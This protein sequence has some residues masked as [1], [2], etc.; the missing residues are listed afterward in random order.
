MREHDPVFQQ[1]GLDGETPIWFLTRYDDVVAMLLDDERFVL[2][3]ALALTPEEL[4]AHPTPIPP[5]LDELINTHVLTTDGEDHRRL[6]RLV[7]KA[8]TPSMVE[9][10]RPRIQEIADELLDRVEA[11]AASRP[12]RQ[13]RVPA[14][15]HR[16]RRAARDPGRGSRPLPRL[17][18]HVRQP[19]RSATT[20]SASSSTTRG[21][22]STYLTELFERR[23]AS[24]PTIS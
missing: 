3:P 12:G 14:A 15:D 5:E 21:S 22:S 23:R 11:D 4:E 24:R 10:L 18:E 9:Q 13:L 19:R 1:P 2:D 17:V 7:T 8:F 16:H 20:R 6:R